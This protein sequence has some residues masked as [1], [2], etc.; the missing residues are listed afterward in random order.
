MEEKFNQV[1]YQNDYNKSKYDRISLM[2]PKG[3]KDELKAHADV[4]DGGSV[5]GFINRAIR[6]TITR[7]NE[8]K[9]DS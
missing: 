8:E 4:H 2:L 3:F 1:K 6:E 5:N 9:K 7:D